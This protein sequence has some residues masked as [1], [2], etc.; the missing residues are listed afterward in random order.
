MVYCNALN[1]FYDIGDLLYLY[2][3]TTLMQRYIVLACTY[4]CCCAGFRIFQPYTSFKLT[5]KHG[6]GG[7]EI[8][9][10]LKGMTDCFPKG[11]TTPNALTG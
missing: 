7:T 1:S 6:I 3:E 11:R 9:N 2:M 10:Y 5:F 8:T 4:L